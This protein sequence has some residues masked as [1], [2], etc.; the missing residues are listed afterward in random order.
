MLVVLIAVISLSLSAIWPSAA[1][2]ADI[3]EIV[4]LG[5]LQEGLN[6]P[7]RIDV[8]AQGN[9]YVAD[10]R[11]NRIVRFDSVGSLQ[12]VFSVTSVSGAALAVN[13][14]GTLIY[15]TEKG[16]RIAILDGQ[17]G[18]FVNYLGELTTTG[19]IVVDQ[20]SGDVYV[21]DTANIQVVRY[22]SAGVE[23]N[24]VSGPGEGEGLFLRIS[25]LATNAV[26]S[27]IYIAGEYRAV[28][29]FAGRSGSSTIQIFSF[30][31]VYQST[32]S[33]V[34]TGGAISNCKGIAFG[35][36]GLEFYL[37]RSGTIRILDRT[38]GYLST[39]SV[40]GL[41][42]GL[43]QVPTDLV[44][45]ATSNR[46]L[47]ASDTFEIEIY[48]VNGGTTPLSNQS[49]S[50]PVLVSPIAGGEADSTTP[51][52]RFLNSTD[53]NGDS[54]AYDV[55]IS[56]FPLLSTNQYAGAESH[57]TTALL[58]EN[59]S[60]SWKALARD[61]HGAESGWT[62]E[63]TFF[64]NAVNEAPAQPLLMYG[65]AGDTLAGN[66]LL[67]WSVATDND[68][69]DAVVYRV[70]VA[71]ADTFA[72]LAMSADLG[73]T[74]IQLLDFSDYTTLRN[75][76]G[77]LWRVTAVDTAGLSTVSE[78]GSFI[79]G[80]TMLTVTANL[81]DARVYLGGNAAYAG[82]QVGVAPVEFRDIPVGSYTVVVEHSGCE[83][84]VA[85]VEVTGD[86]SANIS[87]VLNLAVAPSLRRD[88][89][90]RVEKSKLRVG[91]NAA[92]FAV[93]FNNDGMVDLLVA[94]SSGELNL[95]IALS[96]RSS[97]IQYDVAQPLSIDPVAGAVPF[98]VDWN[99]D[100][101]KDLLI[102]GADG[103]VMLFLQESTSSDQQPAFTAGT[104][105]KVN[106]TL[107]DLNVGSAAN[108][109]VVDIDNDGDKDLVV[110]TAAGEL[111]SFLNVGT[112]V[113]P[114]L[115][116]A[117]AIGSFQGQVAPLFIDW[118][119]DGQRN[120][121]LSHAGTL[122]RCV[123][124]EDGTFSVTETLLSSRATLAD[125]TTRFF[126]VDLDSEHGKD[127]FAGF[128]DGKVTYFRSAG[129]DY[130][131]SVT[132]ALLDKVAQVQALATV[133]GVDVQFG[134]VS[135][136]IT[137]EDLTAA[138][139][140]TKALLKIVP[141]GGELEVAAVELLELLRR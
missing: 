33:T 82:N 114:L 31:G 101:R 127:V 27:E 89:G 131:P 11:T 135:A 115:A 15:A 5:Q 125:A 88:I 1:T 38:D 104:P 26:T 53:V 45:D 21:V 90:L 30:E 60:Y 71:E 103:R 123:R 54:I 35:P 10:A 17:T 18:D 80:T 121:L 41:G 96:Q 51:Q 116:A 77:Y 112:D 136:A 111:Y 106:N 102:G 122:M 73:L 100:N 108:P 117:T 13:A 7:G 92:P 69:N 139:K 47:V 75:G 120:L 140:L 83:Q 74:E 25:E 24:T 129:R 9:L 63:Q 19:D 50:M 128:A 78:V 64:V 119:A 4:S 23:L 124:T 34:D 87:A 141:T 46:L 93:D 133:A 86:A 95:F 3:P 79:Y 130:M 44:Y 132:G 81:P 55:D 98:V 65:A 28:G 97:R 134:V 99:N 36:N 59:A 52:L 137:A 91:M 43:M 39:Y 42:D 37:D 66:G 22:N 107:N 2:A 76:V 118:D 68:P 72:E 12:N 94:D 32:I 58:I 109:A 62:Q 49:P 126:V 110:G 61:E 57:V 40:K 29:E 105:L 20:L 8:D 6:T 56:G 67:G 113:E 16:G 70:E 138:A 14:G 48:G 84:F 85:Q